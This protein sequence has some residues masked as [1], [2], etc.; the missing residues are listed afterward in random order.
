ML[1]EDLKTHD[2]PGEGDRK[3]IVEDD[4]EEIPI[5]IHGEIT[6]ESPASKN[7]KQNKRKSSA[8]KKRTN[9][10]KG[11]KDYE[12][13]Y[14]DNSLNG[15]RKLSPRETS[16]ESEPRPT[17]IIHNND[18]IPRM[19]S[20]PNWNSFAGPMRARKTTV[21]SRDDILGIYSLY[22]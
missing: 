21:K 17:K 11:K 14:E 6:K 4:D 9:L 22:N 7:A 18:A 3:V 8:P 12:E 2:K 16:L 13:E 19:A 15:K 20:P 5:T 10:Q 1:I